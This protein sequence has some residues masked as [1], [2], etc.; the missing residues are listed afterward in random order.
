MGA[1]SAFFNGSFDV[2]I[3]SD[4]LLIANTFSSNEFPIHYHRADRQ[5]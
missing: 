3:N 1:L 4:R 2:Y 5:A